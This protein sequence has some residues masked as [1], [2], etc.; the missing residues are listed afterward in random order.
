MM[1]RRDF[2]AASAGGIIMGAAAPSSLLALAKRTGKPIHGGWIPSR[3]ETRRFKTQQ[4]TPYFSQAAKS[5]AGTGSGKQAFL[6]KF[7]ERTTRGPLVPH[8]QTVGD[9]FVKGTIVQTKHGPVAIE[10]I[11]IGDEIFTGEGNLT[12]VISTREVKPKTPLVTIKIMGGEDTHCTSDH[13]FLVYR[14]G[15]IAGRRVNKSYYERCMVAGQGN[16]SVIDVYEQRESTWVQACDLRDT[17]YLLTPRRA[18]SIPCPTD[19]D[20]DWLFLLGHFIGDG[21]ASGG[22]VEHTFSLDEEWLVD[23]IRSIYKKKGYTPSYN[24]YKDRDAC[25]LRVHSRQL[26]REFRQHF[27]HNKNK[28]FPAWAAGRWAILQGLK[29]A[30]GWDRGNKHVIDNSSREVIYGAYWSL[31]QLGEEP[32]INK[33]KADSAGRYPNAKPC[34]RLTW[35]DGKKKQYTWKDE[36]FYCRPVICVQDNHTPIETVYD[37]GVQ[38]NHHSFIANGNSAHNCVSQA[39]GLGVDILDCV[40]IS[41]GRGRWKT[42]CATEPIYAGGRVEVGGGTIK[43]DGMHGS[44]A[45]KWCRDYGVLLRRPYLL[46]KY[47]FTTYSG[48]KAR[49]W[50]HECDNCTSWGGGVPD[51][52]E[53][54]ARRRPIK[55][56]TLVNSWEEARDAIFNG[57]PV[58]LCSKAGF[59][60]KRDKDGFAKQNQIWYHSMLLAGIDDNKTRPG[61]LV[62]NSW[63]P[64]W[65]SGPTRFG[66][67]AGSFWVDAEVI[68]RMVKEEDSF[69]MSNYR[70]YRRQRLDY[71]L[72]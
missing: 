44:W 69:A 72:F 71:H 48:S 57:Y 67:P 30:D 38:D 37:I 26:V 32:F 19:T 50:A 10:D 46:G 49:S 23:K 66:Q 70:D 11:Q 39:W 9:C 52:L 1:N 62:I 15:S 55:T 17:D 59:S 40:Q 13:E 47:D 56:V 12:R 31:I 25:R 58:A 41:H 60:D 51:E 36:N 65:I 54:I 35:R 3:Q 22:T 29:A 34:Y 33:G 5:L 14:M 68:D 27:Y 63:G 20:P 21:H 8:E 6:W 18:H 53:P 4:R 2:L 24:K 45:A 7:F 61:G 43:Y 28:N 42:K 64:D 16:K